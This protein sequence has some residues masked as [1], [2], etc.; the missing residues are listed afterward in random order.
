MAIP[1]SNLLMADLHTSSSRTLCLPG[2]ASRVTCVAALACDRA[3]V[4]GVLLAIS[5]FA[6]AARADDDCLSLR[7]AAYASDAQ[8]FAGFDEATGKN[9]RNYPPDKGSDIRHI[10]IELTIP[11]MDQPLLDGRETLTFAPIG[12]A[13]STLTL[14]ARAMSIRSVTSPG[15]KVSFGYDGMVLSIAMDPPVPMGEEAS[16]EIG[17]EL[18]D[19]PDGLLWTGANAA[20]PT[21]TPQIHTQGEAETNSFWFPCRDFPNDRATTELIATVPEGFIV[22]SNGHLVSHERKMMVAGVPGGGDSAM[23]QMEEW[24]W[25]QDKPHVAYLVSM[26]VGKFD[27]VDVGSKALPMPVY[28]PVGRGGDV[29]G[30]FG[31]TPQMVAV[32][33]DLFRQKY[34]WD[35][36]AQLVVTNFNAGGMEN[37]SATTLHDGSIIDHDDLDDFEIEGLIAH[38]LGHQWFG[39]LLT[40]DSWGHL[41]LNEGFATYL[42]GLW[43]EHRVPAA[44]EPFWSGGEVAYEQNVLGWFDRVT[45]SD[46][47]SAPKAVGMTSNIYSNPGDVFGRPANPYPKG[48]SILHMLRR[49]LGDEVFFK[50]LQEYVA[51]HKFQTVETSDLRRVLEQVSGDS[52]ERFFW[53]WCTRPGI[54]RVKVETTWDAGAKVVKVVAHQTQAIDGDNPAFEFDVPILVRVSGGSTRS[55][56]MLVR[57]R[58]ATIEIAAD[59]EPTRVEIDPGATVLAQWTITQN[60]AWTQ[61]QAMAGSTLISRIR[62][63]RMLPEPKPDEPTVLDQIALDTSKPVTERLEAFRKWAMA[64]APERARRFLS[65][66]RW[67][68]REAACDKLGEFNTERFKSAGEET[69]SWIRKELPDIARGD[70]SLR[71]RCAAIRAMAKLKDE[72]FTSQVMAAFDA[73]SH[74]DAY[75]MAAIDAASSLGTKEALHRVAALCGPSHFARTRGAAIDAVTKLAR[76]DPEFAVATL[77]QYVNDRV[78]RVQ[79]AAGDGLVRLKDRRGVRMFDEAM[80]R[81]RSLPMRRQMEQWQGQL[82]DDLEHER[83]KGV[84][85]A[86]SPKK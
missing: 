55:A 51:R 83:L 73:D 59:Q 60:N 40:C 35:R 56:L 77:G 58:D 41:W 71:V 20:M 6:N 81:E 52:L 4:T 74:T 16:V 33:E 27:V 76:Q 54:P 12:T 14:D 32:F 42:S 29:P 15:R 28:V 53:Q 9:L 80:A 78:V 68:L 70:S 7:A 38:E 39:D 23:K 85:T 69:R 18:N 62:A 17:Y 43:A 46:E 57:G 24:H 48:A 26:V 21:R 84:T 3:A 13:Q 10:K 2:K 5:F 50:G 86:D 45:G 66:D 65:A 47:G 49:R 44:G 34:P 75:R 8:T 22:S 30:T 63:I 72:S 37:T 67:E 19:P 79:R 61:S 1:R 31:R 36:Y 11:S 64:S 25:A 82:E